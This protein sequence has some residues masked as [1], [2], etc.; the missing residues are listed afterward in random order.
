[1][2]LEGSISDA[3]SSPNGACLFTTNQSEGNTR[4]RCFHWT[5]FGAKAGIEI[6]W[7]E[8]VPNSS[9]VAV[10]SV[11]DRSSTHIIFLD[12]RKATCHSL[13]IHITR[14]SSEFTFR[15]SS[16]SEGSDSNKKRTFNNSLIDCHA[17]VWTRFPIHAAIR[18][19][20][21][22]S[23]I[24]HPRSVLF[25]SSA[26]TFSFQQYFSSLVREFETKIKKPT[27]SLLKRIRVSSTT[28]GDLGMGP[29]PEV[30]EL[31]AGDWLVGLFCLIPIHLAVTGSN[32]F[33]P[34]KDGIISP[35]FEQSLLGANVAQISEA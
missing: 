35:E 18:R 4:I 34:L 13:H 11:G 12:T 29:P 32:R 30:S 20:T 17:E 33:I 3:F 26:S 5:S 8:N 28:N 16:T 7:P 27:K 1:L 24:H 22:A 23:A 15:S 31:Q 2:D 10:S 21:M 19:E 6:Q 9:Q 25:V 14:K